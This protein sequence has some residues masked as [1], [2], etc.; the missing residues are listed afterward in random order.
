MFLL[1][2]KIVIKPRRRLYSPLVMSLVV[3]PGDGL[4]DGVQGVRVRGAGEEEHAHPQA[5]Q[6]TSPFDPQHPEHQL[7]HPHPLPGSHGCVLCVCLVFHTVSKRNTYR[8]PK[9]QTF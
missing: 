7:S 6:A 5:S 2:A 9:T 3:A 1:F 4:L 8:H